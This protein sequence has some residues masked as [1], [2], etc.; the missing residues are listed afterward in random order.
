[1][2]TDIHPYDEAVEL[3]D[4]PPRQ[5]GVLYGIIGVLVGVIITVAY[6]QMRPPDAISPSALA[7]A[8]LSQGVKQPAP[9]SD[10]ETKP[11]VKTPSTTAPQTK[12][13]AGKAPPNQAT[14][15]PVAGAIQPM[16]PF[17]GTQVQ[18]PALEGS[19]TT[20]EGEGLPQ[21]TGPGAN[22]EPPPKASGAARLV[23]ATVDGSASRLEDLRA[24]AGRH[25]ARART[26]TLFRDDAPPQPGLLVLVPSES[27]SG[28]LSAAGLGVEEDWHGSVGGR[29]SMAQAPAKKALNAL[30]AR[31]KELLAVYTDDSS[32][33]RHIDEDIAQAASALNQLRVPGDPRTA[34]VRILLRG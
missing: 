23:L 2:S 24:L 10:G 15:P 20:G 17:L 4:E 34:V 16:N 6:T 7:A 1:M 5:V 21:P 30:L 31:K 22:A 12:P 11:P 9:R 33:V 13:A 26:F 28:F 18:P 32:T 29:Q 27:L 19:L 3:P 8:T 14:G 25:N